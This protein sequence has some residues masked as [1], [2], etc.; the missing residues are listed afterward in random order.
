[1]IRGKNEGER[2]RKAKKKKGKKG[3]KEEAART[4]N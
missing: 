1:M 4:L 2:R 3:R